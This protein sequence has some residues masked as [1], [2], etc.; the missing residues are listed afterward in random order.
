[1]NTI[2]WWQMCLAMLKHSVGQHAFALIL[3]L[4]TKAYLYDA[5]VKRGQ[6]QKLERFN[7]LY[8]PC[9]ELFGKSMGSIGFGTIGRATAR[10]AEGFGMKV[11]AYDVADI[12]HTGYRNTEFD[13]LIKNSDVISIHCPLTDKT[14]KLIAGE[15]LMMMKNTAILVNTARGSIVNEKNRA[16]ALDTGQTAGAG[17]DV[18][19][20]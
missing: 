18:L 7:L 6:W 11:L 1:V 2:S 19:S 4:A 8:Y 9:F 14:R 20:Q 10:I 12:S 3:N 13:Y 17:I 15:K 16:L 5:D